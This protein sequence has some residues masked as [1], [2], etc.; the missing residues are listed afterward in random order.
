MHTED[1]YDPKWDANCKYFD[2]CIPDSGL[3]PSENDQGGYWGYLG[4]CDIPTRTA[5][6]MIEF[7]KNHVKDLDFALWT[8]DNTGH[9]VWE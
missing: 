9:D 7:I 8:G 6:K 1:K 3:A 5:Q 4:F 2:C